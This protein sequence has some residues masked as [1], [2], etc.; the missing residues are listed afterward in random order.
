YPKDE[1]IC[2]TGQYQ[3]GASAPSIS[4]SD[5]GRWHP[6]DTIGPPTNHTSDEPGRAMFAGWVVV[7]KNCTMTVTLSWYV[8]PQGQNHP[9]TL[10][11]QRQAGT[12]PELDLTILLPSSMCATFGITAKH[13]DEILSEDRSF[14]LKKASS[15]ANASA[16]CY[17]QPEV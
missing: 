15:S 14:S 5:G 12:F 17:S 9:Y 3:P 7:P 16:D 13:F 11:V 6:L 10:L 4:D 2:P 8:P 1:L